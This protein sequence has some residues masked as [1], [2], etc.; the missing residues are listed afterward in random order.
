LKS[1]TGGLPKPLARVC[2]K[3][4]LGRQF[5]MLAR[6]GFGDVVLLTGHGAEQIANYCG[7]GAAWGLKV[8]CF[9]ERTPRGTAGAVIDHL[10]ELAE[11]FVVMYGDTV[12]EIDL[13]RLTA[14][15]VRHNADATIFLHPNDHPFDSDIVE[16]DSG[17]FVRALHPYPH[18]AGK[19]L[20]NLVN[21]ALYIVERNSLVDLTGLPDRPDFAKHVFPQMLDRGNRLFGYR[22][23]EYIKDAGTPERLAK[24]ARDIETGRVDS[25]S[26]RAPAPAIFLDR[27]GV[28]NDNDGYVSRPEQLGL[29]PGVAEA[30]A[31][32]NHTHYRSVVITNQPVIARG[33]CTEDGLAEIHVKLD[34]LL[35]RDKAYIDRLYY[36]PHHPDGGYPGEVARL[37]IAC[38]CRKPETGLVDRAVDDLN[39]NVSESWFIGDSTTDMELSRRRNMRFML[40]RTGLA[41]RDGKYPGRPDFVALDLPAALEFILGAWPAIREA[42]RDLAASIRPGQ[43]VA[44][45]GLARSGKSSIASELKYALRERSISAV[46][47]PLDNWLRPE[48]ERRPGVLGR[49]DMDG[50]EE[51]L[52]RLIFERSAVATPRYD[53]LT[54]VSL[55]NGETIAAGPDDVIILDGIPSL[56][57]EKLA[58]MA[59]LRLFAECSEGERRRRFE[60]EYVW[61]GLHKNDIEMV[62]E[63]RNQDEAPLVRANA[64][65]ADLVLRLGNQ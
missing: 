2:G 28:L 24:V 18:P 47:A 11:R 53:R 20:P 64:K 4:L 26:L 21:A 55:P 51:A 35:A 23:P 10:G 9:A 43:V 39:I 62:Y 13:A 49:Y 41:G 29:F 56:L 60:R 57:S 31:R 48:S 61:R 17:G 1:V 25:L 45:G 30:V 37:K 3:T 16:I 33:D 40:V 19:R 58:A 42:A 15:H 14:A 36:C 50:L 27:D 44:I 22:S 5:E 46:I 38:A 54:R 52:A 65:Q 12:L 59:S 34:S 6:Q 32:L 63:Q 8:R 7:D